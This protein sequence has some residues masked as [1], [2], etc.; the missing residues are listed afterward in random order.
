MLLSCVAH[1][2]IVSVAA[3]QDPHL[4]PG[5][6]EKKGV[7]VQLKIKSPNCLLARVFSMRSAAAC[8]SY[9]VSRQCKGSPHHRHGCC[10]HKHKHLHSAL[11]ISWRRTFVSLLLFFFSFSSLPHPR[12]AVSNLLNLKIESGVGHPGDGNV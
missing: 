10:S 7:E 6:C 12:D 3:H 2:Q 5:A 11:D 9:T 8:L 4:R 1:G